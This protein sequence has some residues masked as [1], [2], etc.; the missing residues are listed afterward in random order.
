[1]DPSGIRLPLGGQKE[2]PFLRLAE[3]LSGWFFRISRIPRV[4]NISRATFF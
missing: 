4:F 1:V 3:K 2:P